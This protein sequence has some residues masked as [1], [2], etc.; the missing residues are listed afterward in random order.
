[1]FRRI[2]DEFSAGYA[3]IGELDYVTAFTP[4]PSDYGL[5]APMTPE[6]ARLILKY[7]CGDDNSNTMFDCQLFRGTG[8]LYHQHDFDEIRLY[9]FNSDVK[10]L[11]ENGVS[12]DA[13]DQRPDVK[14][15]RDPDVVEDDGKF[16]ERI[17]QEWAGFLNARYP[18]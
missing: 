17:G 7:N 6:L 4:R 5:E 13:W 3:E 12:L 9:L 1:M 15:P 16:S 2:D 10:K 8:L 11:I 18:E 14:V